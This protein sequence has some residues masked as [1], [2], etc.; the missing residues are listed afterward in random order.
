MPAAPLPAG[1][2]KFCRL[3][4]ALRES[5]V[6]CVPHRQG[7]GISAALSLSDFRGNLFF[8]SAA[9][10]SAV[11]SVPDLPPYRGK[12]F[13]SATP[14]LLSC[15]YTFR[16]VIWHV[17]RASSFNKP[18][19]CWKIFSLSVPVSALR[20]VPAVFLHLIPAAPCGASAPSMCTSTSI[21]AN[22]LL[23]VTD[24]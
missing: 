10:A 1:T 8:S 14:H 3:F 12:W 5:S 7:Q 20:K 13:L 16:G 21:H 17:Q 23:S 6:P 19:C 15:L 2:E 4:A 9:A 11:P 22:A 18:F 24:S